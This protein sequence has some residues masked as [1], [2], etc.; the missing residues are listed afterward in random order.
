MKIIR[1]LYQ[2]ALGKYHDFT[3]GTLL[4]SK[5]VTSPVNG[6]LYKLT[7]APEHWLKDFEASIDIEFDTSAQ[8]VVFNSLAEA[9]HFFEVDYHAAKDLYHLEHLLNN[10][11]YA[12]CIGHNYLMYMPIYLSDKDMRATG[13]KVLGADSL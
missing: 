11:P 1:A 2:I 9:A 5:Y 6:A 13:F 10:N 8:F 7:V 4:Q 12:T 3:I